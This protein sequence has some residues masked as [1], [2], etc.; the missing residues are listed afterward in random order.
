MNVALD[1]RVRLVRRILKGVVLR[2]W[3]NCTC[4]LAVR[5]GFSLSEF[6]TKVL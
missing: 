1:E 5:G 3:F 4:R 2:S 6:S